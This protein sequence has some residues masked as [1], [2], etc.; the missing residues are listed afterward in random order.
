[1]IKEK[2]LYEVK[3]E[4]EQQIKKLSLNGI[5]IILCEWNENNL[6][7]HTTDNENAKKIAGLLQ[8]QC[9]QCLESI[10]TVQLW[11]SSWYLH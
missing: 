8:Q 1:M 2:G 6:K 9:G 5:K 3:A 7:L 11:V 4:I 10:I